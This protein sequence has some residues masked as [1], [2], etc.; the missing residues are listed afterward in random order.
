MSS[1]DFILFMLFHFSG[2][3]VFKECYLFLQNLYF[4]T[5]LLTPGEELRIFLD[6]W[7]RPQLYIDLPV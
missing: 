5:V 3:M 6:T 4:H 1:K 7:A 2:Y